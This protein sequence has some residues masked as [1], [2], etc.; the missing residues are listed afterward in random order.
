MCVIRVLGKEK[1]E[2]FRQKILR[3][4]FA[5]V[6][7]NLKKT[8]K[9][10]YVKEVQYTT[11]RIQTRKNCTKAHHKTLYQAKVSFKK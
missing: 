5:N 11:N 8:I 3:E 6:I 7:T 1:K 10:P 9:T 2:K 4:I